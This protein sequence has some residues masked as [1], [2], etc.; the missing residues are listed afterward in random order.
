MFSVLN[1]SND[2]SKSEEFSLKDI[3]IFVDSEE[4][5]WFKRA[6][7]VKFLGLEDIRT[8]LNGLKK[9][10]ITRQELIPT[11]Q[12]GLDPKTSKTRRINSSQS[13]ESCMS[14]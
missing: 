14:L 1:A 7:E 9:R 3:E 13:L 8:S 10:E 5:N 11:H 6:H 2:S 12:V 4:Q